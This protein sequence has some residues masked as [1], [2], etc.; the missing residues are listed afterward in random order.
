MVGLYEPLELPA[1]FL[2]QIVM[3]AMTAA[4]AGFASLLLL[5]RDRE[6]RLRT[7]GLALFLLAGAV[8]ELDEL[9]MYAGGYDAAPWSV[10][11][12]WPLIVIGGPAIL[13]YVRD[14]TAA[15]RPPMTPARFARYAWAVPAGYLIALPFFLLPGEDKLAILAGEGEAGGLAAAVPAVLSVLFLV[16]ALV[17]LVLAVRELLV[18]MRSIRDF[19]AN[20]E[21]KSL[22]WLRVVLLVLS[23]AWVWGAAS[24]LW[25][26]DDGVPQWQGLMAT[27]LEMGWVCA[28]GF[29]G[30]R[31]GLIFTARTASDPAA[32]SKYTRSAL[33]DA[34][35]ERIAARIET[36]MREQHLYRNPALSLRQLSDTIRV[37]QNYISQTL[38]DRLG[39]NF[40]DYVNAWRIADACR[41]LEAGGRVL[42]TAH[43]TG[44]NSR[45]TFNAAFRKHTG[46]TPSAWRRQPAA[47]PDGLPR[48]DRP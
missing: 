11:L 19:F 13:L 47:W 6:A 24:T 1:L 17:S 9:Y 34:R 40:F 7:L 15:E 12:V 44:F 43:E 2:L 25:R 38:N 4:V 27:V 14:M 30:V 36:A 37:S 8:S 21:D 31:Q 20:I 46:T 29:F 26:L 3:S 22:N 39:R 18:H 23:A 45:S 41:R 42:E 10:A 16:I 33:D 35:M 32:S 48:P 5:S 28:F